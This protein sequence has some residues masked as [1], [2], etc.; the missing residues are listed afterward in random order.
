MITLEE[1]EIVSE[2]SVE[3]SEISTLSWQI[4][5]LSKIISKIIK[6]KN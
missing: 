6:E 4:F 2:F 5:C 1:T 3:N